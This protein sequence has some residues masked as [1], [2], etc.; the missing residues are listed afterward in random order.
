M[1]RLRILPLL[2]LLV[3]DSLDLVAEGLPVRYYHLVLAAL[4][5][6]HSVV[7]QNP[8]KIVEL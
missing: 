1:L 5:Q 8:R 4:S 2:Y 3:E 7:L 6:Q